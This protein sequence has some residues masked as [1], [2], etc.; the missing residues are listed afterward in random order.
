MTPVKVCGIGLLAP[1]VPDWNEGRTQLQ[2]LGRLLSLPFP[3]PSPEVLPANE[4][5]RASDTT[6][7]ALEVA[8]QAIDGARIAPADMA[9]V[10][11]SADGDGAI[12]HQICDILA[13]TREVSPT[14]FHNS[15]HNAPAGYWSIAMDA[16]RSATS[17]AAGDGSF[18]AGLLHAWTHVRVENMPVLLV[19]Y[20]LPLPFPLSEC[21]PLGAGF[22]MALLLAPHAEAGMKE[23]SVEAIDD[24]P[25]AANPPEWIPPA[26]W[27]APAARSLPLLAALAGG[28]AQEVLLPYVEGAA[29][30]VQVK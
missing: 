18:S 25:D 8:R 17:I 12:L 14:R 9:T 24:R 10:F 7:V 5:R 2:S 13:T 26:V 21:R 4:R 1:G 29:L 11:V 20:D 15:V 3:R 28:D 23:I 6:R 16:R 22:A 27:A 30:R 19:A